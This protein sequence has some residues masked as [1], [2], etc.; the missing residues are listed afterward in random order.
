MFSQAIQSVARTLLPAP[1]LEIPDAPPTYLP[2]SEPAESPTAAAD[3]ESLLTPIINIFAV[4]K[5]DKPVKVQSSSSSGG[6]TSYDYAQQFVMPDFSVR[7]QSGG[8][9][10]GTQIALAGAAALAL[11]L[12]FSAD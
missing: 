4:G 12:I 6:G 2:Y 3:P 1:T 10:S 5:P 8:M 11:L 7:R 9:S